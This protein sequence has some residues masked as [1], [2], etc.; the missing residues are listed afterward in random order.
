M[1]RLHELR[2]PRVH[3]F[4][5]RDGMQTGVCVHVCVCVWCVSCMSGVCVCGVW[6]VYVISMV[7]TW[8]GG[9]AD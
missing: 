5:E 8:W 3:L 9:V 4:T 6:C 2:V 7:Y 1:W